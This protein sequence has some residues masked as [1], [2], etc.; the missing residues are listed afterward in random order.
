M[1]L[2]TDASLAR[3]EALSFAERAEQAVDRLVELHGNRPS[4]TN[5]AALGQTRQELGLALKLAEVHATLAVAD[6]LGEIRAMLAAR[7]VG[8]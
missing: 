8:L 3:D 1:T 7:V 6:E 2:S 5:A 4:P